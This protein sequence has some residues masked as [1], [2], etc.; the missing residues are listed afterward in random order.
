MNSIAVNDSGPLQTRSRRV[1]INSKRNSNTPHTVHQQIQV[2]PLAFK[3]G[4]SIVANLFEGGYD[5]HTEHE[6]D[7]IPLLGNLEDALDYL[8]ITAEELGLGD[9]L[10]AY[11]T[12][13]VMVTQVESMLEP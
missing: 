5:T 6:K 2:T 7:P 12:F 1:C 3:A 8:W 11:Q 4:V 9:R 13:D 10:V